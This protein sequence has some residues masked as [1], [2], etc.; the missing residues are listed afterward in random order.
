M[1]IRLAGPHLIL[2]ISTRV[3]T[4][5]HSLSCPTGGFPTIRHNELR[6]VFASM[7]SDVCHDVKVETMLHQL[8][9]ETLPKKSSIREDEACM[10]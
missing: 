8:S 6:N 9:G 10:S 3:V 2:L 5:D 1:H 4:I 7:L